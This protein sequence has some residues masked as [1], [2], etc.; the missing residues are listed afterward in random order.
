MEKEIT[1][2]FEEK[3]IFYFHA[4][5]IPKNLKILE[6]NKNNKKDLNKSFPN[7]NILNLYDLDNIEEIH[8]SFLTCIE[9]LYFKNVKNIKF[10]SNKS[11]ISLNK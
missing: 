2:I 5:N 8:C 4:T 3:N 9:S 10:L 11:N 1:E 6:V 7:L